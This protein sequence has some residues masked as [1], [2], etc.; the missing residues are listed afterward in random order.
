MLVLSL[1]L[2]GMRRGRV[3]GPSFTSSQGVDMQR[4]FIVVV[5]TA[6]CASYLWAEEAEERRAFVGASF[7]NTADVQDVAR[8][9][10]IRLPPRGAYVINVVHHY[11]A[12]DA[13]VRPGD[14][15]AVVE[16]RPVRSADHLIAAM[17]ERFEQGHD[18]ARLVIRRMI[19][20]G[21]RA[22]WT[23]ELARV[24]LATEA[25]T[26]GR[27]VSVEE[28]EMSASRTYRHRHAPTTLR[29]NQLTLRVV[30]IDERRHLVMR[31]QYYGREWLF[32]ERIS[33]RNAQGLY[34]ASL[35][36]M[37]RDNA[38]QVWEWS[39][40]QLDDS[41]TEFLESL[42]GD[43]VKVRLSGRT[44]RR[45]RTLSDAERG[46]MWAVYRH[47]VTSGGELPPTSVVPTLRK[48]E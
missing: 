34:R 24:Q 32:I 2:S 36:R 48:V 10:G 21:A 9:H 43:D 41:W 6:M 3:I 22:R 38:T 5:A 16:G 14:V 27:L 28:D 44:F 30:E 31:V 11:P 17:Q 8:E 20:D 42:A 4:A 25:E 45:D 23:R 19:E 37:H 7:V 29:L 18:E 12:A 26:L 39:D 33:L 1:P 13:G 15:I 35:D 46:R 40:L 47:F